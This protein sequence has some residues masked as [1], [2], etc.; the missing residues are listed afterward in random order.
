MRA[1]T[2]PTTGDS[3]Q[4]LSHCRASRHWAPLLVGGLGGASRRL[5]RSVG[6]ETLQARRQVSATA[7]AHGFSVILEVLRPLHAQRFRLPP[8]EMD[9]RT[10]KD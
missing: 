3:Q 6:V 10:W 8:A 2:E 9:A 5:T 1:P 7:L 4:W